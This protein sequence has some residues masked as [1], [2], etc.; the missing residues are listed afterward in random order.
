MASL[1]SRGATALRR[2]LSGVFSKASGGLVSA[3]NFRQGYSFGITGGYTPH[4]PFTQAWQL[5]MSQTQNGR[6]PSLLAFSAVYS[7]VTIIS[8]DL[9]KLPIRVMTKDDEDDLAKVATKSPYHR[10][11]SNPNNYQTSM[12]FFQF[13]AVSRLIRGNAYIYKELDARGVP[14]ALHVLHPDRTEPLVDPVTKSVFYRYTPNTNDMF[15]VEQFQSGDKAAQVIIPARFII[16]DRIN[17]LWHPLIGTTPLFAAAV[18]ATTGGRI[19]LNSERLFGNMARPSGVLTSDT[20]IND[21]T[22][23]RLKEQFEANYSAGNIGRTAVLGDGLKWQTMVMTSTDAQLIEQL[24]WTIEDVA[25]VFRVPM[26]LLADQ[27]KVNWKNSEQAARSYYSG[28]LQFHVEGIEARLNSEFGLDGVLSYVEFDVE[29]MFRMDTQERFAAYGEGIKGGVLAPNEARKKEGLPPAKG[30]EEPRMQMQYVPLSTPIEQPAPPPQP[31]QT[32]APAPAPAPA[33]GG[34]TDD[35]STTEDAS[36]AT[37]EVLDM[38]LAV[39]RSV[40]RATMKIQS[41]EV[42]Q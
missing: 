2:S 36:K 23:K 42:S 29:G 34:E 12:D 24:K 11:I 27:S 14:T 17:P 7:C 37:Q 15:S 6:D 16:H 9:S 41:M 28:C 5:G 38:L 39:E 20:T 30:G 3:N 40:S 21:V 4:E 10:L 18:S 35:S 22:A 8:Q 32:P 13:W 1:L 26:F 31:T 33:D 25:R 19:L